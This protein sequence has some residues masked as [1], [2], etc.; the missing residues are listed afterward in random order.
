MR[1]ESCE[2]SATQKYFISQ[3]AELIYMVHYPSMV[4]GIC[5][6]LLGVLIYFAPPEAQSLKWLDVPL[7]I[8]SVLVIVIS[9]LARR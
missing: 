5:L 2:C 4:L 9:F 6:C 3:L 8:I 7:V 1:L